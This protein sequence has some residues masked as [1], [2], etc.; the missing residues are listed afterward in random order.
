MF[1][2]I[3]YCQQQ[4]DPGQQAIGCPSDMLHNIQ[5]DLFALFKVKVSVEMGRGKCV[6]GRYFTVLILDYIYP[7][8]LCW[9]KP[10]TTQLH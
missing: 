3:L 4:G 9:P 1:T 6:Y 8:I 2:L 10:Q 7:Q 5:V